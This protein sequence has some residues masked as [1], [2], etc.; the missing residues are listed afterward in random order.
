M[1]PWIIWISSGLGQAAYPWIVG[2]VWINDVSVSGWETVLRGKTGAVCKS[3][4][5]HW[6]SM[7]LASLGRLGQLESWDNLHPSRQTGILSSGWTGWGNLQIHAYHWIC[8]A[9]AS[10]GRLGSWMA[11]YSVG[12]LDLHGIGMAQLESW[13]NL[14]S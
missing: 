2:S 9:L 1:H 3:M 13:D 11:D 4:D 8:M 7:A 14:G 6:I 12:Q 10:L 5:T